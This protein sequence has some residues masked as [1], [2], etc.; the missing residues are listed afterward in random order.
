MRL[1]IQRITAEH[2]IGEGAVKCFLR[3][4]IDDLKLGM[5][6]HPDTNFDD[7]IT[8][9]RNGKD[10][11]CF[12]KDEAEALN[13]TL[14][15]CFEQCEKLSLDI[16]AIGLEIMEPILEKA[17]GYYKCTC[18]KCGWIGRNLTAYEVNGH[19]CNKYFFEIS[20]AKIS[21]SWNTK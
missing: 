9:S 5:G 3:E 21:D 15:E 19:K 14:A 7:Y 20:L 2:I 6:F 17:F 16:Y 4:C 1:Q 13:T 18:T 12:T 11:N 8:K 10:K